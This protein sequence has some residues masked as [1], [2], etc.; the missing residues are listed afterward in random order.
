MSS[1]GVVYSAFLFAAV[2][3]FFHV[4]HFQ[5]LFQLVSLFLFLTL[6]FDQGLASP[7]HVSSGKTRLGGELE[8]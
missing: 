3:I 4:I 2:K 7:S 8:D 1:P 5:A 6:Y